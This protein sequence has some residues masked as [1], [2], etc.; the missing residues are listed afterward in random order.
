M[1]T[2]HRFLMGESVKVAIEGKMFKG[3]VKGIHAADIEVS[4][5]N[6]YG[7]TADRINVI[8]SDSYTVIFYEK[9]PAQSNLCDNTQGEGVSNEIDNSQFTTQS[10]RGVL[11]RYATDEF[12]DAIQQHLPGT[13]M[14]RLAEVSNPNYPITPYTMI[15]HGMMPGEINTYFNNAYQMAL[16]GISPNSISTSVDK[17]YALVPFGTEPHP[18]AYY[19]LPR[20]D[21]IPSY[22]VDIRYRLERVDR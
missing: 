5:I 19:L 7:I 16:F 18:G 11:M 13:A 20:S 10:N 22:L 12:G 15:L 9:Q 3:T 14:P 1:T 21:L 17:F 4:E 8:H 6:P 2:R